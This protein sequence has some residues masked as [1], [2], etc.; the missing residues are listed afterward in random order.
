M[1]ASTPTARRPASAQWEPVSRPTDSV[2]WAP[3]R[4]G[5]PT[6]TAPTAAARRRTCRRGLRGRRGRPAGLG[7]GAGR[8][9]VPLRDSARG[10][11][12]GPDTG[13]LLTL[14]GVSRS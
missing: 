8:L 5:T 13:T 2:Q 4:P 9:V 6:P 7:L 14:G 10:T 12:F 11:T 1:P 3:E